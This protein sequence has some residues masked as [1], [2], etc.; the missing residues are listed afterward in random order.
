[1]TVAHLFDILA[2]KQGNRWSRMDKIRLSRQQAR[3]FLL[4]HQ[5]LTNPGI[6]NGKAG[7]M[8]FIQ[9]VGCIQF[10]PLN[11]VGHNH[12]LVLQSRIKNF[13]PHMLDELLYQERLLLDGW[14]KNMSIYA[15]FDWPYFQRNRQN[16]ME[17]FLHRSPQIKDAE[18]EV[19][20][21]IEIN[22]PITSS[23]LDLSQKVDW[24]W[25]PTRLSRAVLEYLY[26]GGKLILHHKTHTRKIYDLASKHLPRE[27]LNS[28]D[29]NLSEEEYHDWHVLR[30]IGSIGLLWNKSG[31]AWLGISGLKSKER[32][33]AFNR[34]LEKEEIIPVE[35]DGVNIDLFLR[36]SDFASLDQV[37]NHLPITDHTFILAPLDNLIWDRQLTRVLFNFEYRWEVYKP[38]ELRNYGYYVLPILSGD[39]FIARFEPGFDKKKKVFW[40]KNWWW[41]NGVELGEEL[42]SNIKNCLVNFCQFLNADTF[43]INPEIPGHDV[44]NRFL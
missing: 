24:P 12:E 36:T 4:T 37:L 1:L 35:V 7:I 43:E 19:Q 27:L 8:D 23:S 25:G 42:I 34:L 10:D 31:D 32:N 6:F 16:F 9:R 2:I 22:G 40:I 28:P 26:F 21:Y 29:P 20:K 33:A 18:S 11:I 30:R 39:R 14:D 15:T 41:E 13:S 44:L 3:N 5:G 38:V 17:Y